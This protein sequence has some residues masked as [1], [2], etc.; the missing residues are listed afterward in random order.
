MTTPLL[1]AQLSDSHVGMALD[2]LEGRLDTL[3]ALHRAVAH[4]ACLDPLPDLVLFTGDLAERGHA[5][6]YEAIAQALASLPMPV[7][8]VPGNHDHPSVARDALPACM[9]VRADAP[10]QTCCYHVQ[11]AGLQLIALDTVVPGRPHGALDSP[12]LDWL[13]RT[14]ARCHDQPVLLFMHHPPLPTGIEAM[15]ACGLLEGG[16]RLAALVRGHGQVQGLLCGHLHRPV[17]MNFGGAPLHVAPSV[18]HQIALDLRPE[19]PLRARLE[20]PKI[21]LHRWS[22]ALGLCTHTSY[23]G[24]FGRGIP[25]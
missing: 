19:A 2:V 4:V 9:P 12:Q 14:L 6:E 5:A 16:D 20:P 17:Q 10:A 23:V 18:A 11:H 15:D 21:S 22:A 24:D 13:E 3:A 1:I 8:A 25:L 7:Y